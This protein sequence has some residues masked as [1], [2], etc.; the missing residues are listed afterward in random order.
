MEQYLRGGKVVFRMVSKGNKRL[1]L[2]IGQETHPRRSSPM[3]AIRHT[4]R[5]TSHREG[6]CGAQMR[7]CVIGVAE[8]AHM[9]ERNHV[10]QCSGFG[11]DKGNGRWL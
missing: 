2:F 1:S 7:V 3:V 5:C 10:E 6:A 4:K 9:A 8:G 11:N